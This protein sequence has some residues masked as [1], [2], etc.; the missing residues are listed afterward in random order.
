MGE[1]E[2][3][4]G[5]GESNSPRTRELGY[6]SRLTV[7]IVEY[8]VLI[9]LFLSF[10]FFLSRVVDDVYTPR[11]YIVLDFLGS[12]LVHFYCSHFSPLVGQRECRA[13]AEIP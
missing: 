12:S 2:K 5:N 7:N 11:K 9:I 10:S 4:R 6:C 13:R 8:R 3:G 1:Q